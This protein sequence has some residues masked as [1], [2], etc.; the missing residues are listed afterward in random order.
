MNKKA[1]SIIEVMIVVLIIW[2]WLIWVFTMIGN[3]YSFLTDIKSKLTALNL[4]R[5]WVEWVFNVRNTNWQRWWWKKDQC[6]LKINPLVDDNNDGC[7]NDTWFGTW[8]YKLYLTWTNQK[9]FALQAQS[10][11]LNIDWAITSNDWNYLLCE[12]NGIISPCSWSITWRPAGYFAPELYF[13]QVRWW[14]LLDKNNN[15]EMTNCS[16]WISNTDCS[17]GRF[18]EKNFCV[19]VVYFAWAKK[20]IT[21]CS[22]MTNFQE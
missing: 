10:P 19:D 16:Y 4:A 5:W 11:A 21:F 3:S 22:V 9:Y 2:T 14:Y 17:D 20:N 8:S 6:W 1:F 7:E 12:E 15:T 18:L 13:Q